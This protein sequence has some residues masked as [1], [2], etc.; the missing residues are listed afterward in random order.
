M[1]MRMIGTINFKKNPHAR[2]LFFRDPKSAA[3]A[4]PK[5]I[6]EMKK[7]QSFVKSQISSP[8]ESLTNSINRQA[9]RDET[10]N[11]FIKKFKSKH[12]KD[13]A[14]I[15]DLSQDDMEDKVSK[16]CLFSYFVF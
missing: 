13:W 8:G 2:S 3:P 14:N 12:E 1:S 5:T 11:E 4:R 7:L 6:A 15:I 16:S 9:Q 10:F